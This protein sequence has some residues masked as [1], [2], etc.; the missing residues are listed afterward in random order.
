MAKNDFFG[1]FEGGA[2]ALLHP[3]GSATVFHMTALLHLNV[4]MCDNKFLQGANY[5]V[6]FLGVFDLNLTNIR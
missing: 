3:P 1:F 5:V 2:F 4:N 6:M